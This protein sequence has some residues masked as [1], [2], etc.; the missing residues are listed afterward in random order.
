MLEQGDIIKIVGQKARVE[1]FKEIVSAG[2][3][4]NSEINMAVYLTGLFAGLIAGTVA[5][6][7]P[8]VL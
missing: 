5:I 3:N 1:A 7:L 2:K 4:N 8:E 6:T